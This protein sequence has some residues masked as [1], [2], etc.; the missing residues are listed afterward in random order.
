ME[1]TKKRIWTCL[2]VVLLVAVVIGIIYYFYQVKDANTVTE[3][4]LIADISN[5]W[6]K[7]VQYVCR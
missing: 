5:G 7:L 1:K 4:T 3:G 6:G 2:L